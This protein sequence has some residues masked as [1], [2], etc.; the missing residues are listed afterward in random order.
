MDKYHKIVTVYERDPDTKYKYL[1]GGRWAKPEFAYLAENDWIW[2]EK[3]D[4]INIRVMWDGNR[5]RYGGKT[6]NSQIPA[7]LVNVMDEMFPTEVF[8]EL[9]PDTPMCLYGEGYGEKIQKK[10]KEYLSGTQSF[11]LFDVVLEMFGCDET[12]LWMLPIN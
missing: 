10:G 6:D 4:G 8:S 9:Y 5:I 12:M 7:F 3:I 2:T 11:I 1:I